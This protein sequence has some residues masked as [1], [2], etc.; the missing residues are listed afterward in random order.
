[1]YENLV[2]LFS[3]RRTPRLVSR[4]PI[5]D[6]D[7]N[8]IL[9]AIKL[10]P[11]FNKVYPYQIHVLTNSEEGTKIKEKLV[12]FYRCQD[13]DGTSSLPGTSLLKKEIAQPLLSGLV[14]VYVITPDN[15]EAAPAGPKVQHDFAMKDATISATY[16]LMAAMSLGYKVGM[17]GS[18]SYNNE[19]NHSACDLF[20]TDIN[21][22]IVLSLTI[23]KDTLPIID[24]TKEKQWYL[25]NK[26][27]VFVRP[28][29]HSN[30][31]AG[32]TILTI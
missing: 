13:D 1:M 17:F 30:V 15:S 14:L 24:P 31:S 9:D 7:V 23:A 5:P 20:N 22:K 21:S 10:A 8:K 4:E 28:F 3:S 25:F 27:P 19:S 16:G 11:S 2:N 18:V 29:K 12:D 6:D 32:P 26:V